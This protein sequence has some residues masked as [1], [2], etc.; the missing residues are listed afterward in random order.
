MGIGAAF[1]AAM[2]KESK[3]ATGFSLCR[4]GAVRL[5]S[6]IVL[7]DVLCKHTCTKLMFLTIEVDGLGAGMTRRCTLNGKGT[8]TAIKIVEN[9][10]R[11]DYRLRMRTLRVQKM[12]D[13]VAAVVVGMWRRTG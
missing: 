13:I 8:C 2:D 1:S 9:M 12:L 3:L 11:V 5:A 4:C 10:G 7:S 6:Y